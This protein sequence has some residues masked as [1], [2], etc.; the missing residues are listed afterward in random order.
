MLLAKPDMSKFKNDPK[1]VKNIERCYNSPVFGGSVF[2]PIGKKGGKRDKENCLQD[3][4][5]EASLDYAKGGGYY[6][7]RKI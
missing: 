3:D 6:A 1:A 7:I 5:K 4:V 2:L